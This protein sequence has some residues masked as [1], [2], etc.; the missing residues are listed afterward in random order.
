MKKP[1]IDPVYSFFLFMFLMA[2]CGLVGPI[3]ED[4]KAKGYILGP[5]PSGWRQVDQDDGGADL[6]WS[7][8]N[9]TYLQLSTV[10]QRYET[11][12]LARLAR[13]LIVGSTLMKI[14]EES[15]IVVDGREGVQLLAQGQVDGVTVES[16]IFVWR[17]DRCLFDVTAARRDAIP[18]SDRLAFGAFVRALKY[19]GNEKP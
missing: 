15:R 7:S 5:L 4:V 14:Q 2:G 8:A 16:I 11:E 10:C 6:V 19:S 13:S 3:R 12:D 1:K 17:K 18:E 9:G